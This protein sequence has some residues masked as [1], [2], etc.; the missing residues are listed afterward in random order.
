MGWLYFAKNEVKLNRPP[1]GWQ[2]GW[3]ILLCIR[4][5]V[6]YACFSKAFSAASL[7]FLVAQ[8]LEAVSP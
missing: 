5:F 4:D 3:L 7:I 8:K 2:E 1:C 6:D